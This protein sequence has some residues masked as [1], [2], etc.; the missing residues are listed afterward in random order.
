MEYISN[1][2]D[3]QRR[4]TAPMPE[5]LARGLERLHAAHQGLSWEPQLCGLMKP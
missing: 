3:M 2:V 5:D 1:G 4:R